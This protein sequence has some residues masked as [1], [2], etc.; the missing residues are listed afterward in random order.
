MG[1]FAAVFDYHDSNRQV[2]RN[3][4]NGRAL[5]LRTK[6]IRL[7]TTAFPG[8]HA[9][10]TDVAVQGSTASVA[11]SFVLGNSPAFVPLSAD[12]E[13]VGDRWVVSTDSICHLADVA[14]L[15]SC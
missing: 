13:F 8:V 7:A 9:A 3:L 5:T 15:A 14:A 11:Y 12:L 4:Q 6:L 1:T 2:V 10:I